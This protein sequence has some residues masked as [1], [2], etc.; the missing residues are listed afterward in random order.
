MAYPTNPIY[1]LIKDPIKNKT[2]AIMTTK[3]S[4]V[5]SIPL[6]EANIDYQAYLEWAKNN[7]AEAAD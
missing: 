7:T 4:T 1:K 2:S 5:I 3:G 6:D